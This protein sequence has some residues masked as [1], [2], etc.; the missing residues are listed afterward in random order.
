MVARRTSLSSLIEKVVKELE[1]LT[2]G[3]LTGKDIIKERYCRI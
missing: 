2:Q 3:H 1:Q